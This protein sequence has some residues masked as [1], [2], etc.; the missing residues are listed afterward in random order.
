[1]D[2]PT[3]AIRELRYVLSDVV[4]LVLEHF[5]AIFVNH[6]SIANVSLAVGVIS[7]KWH[8]QIK[9][10]NEISQTLSTVVTH[11]V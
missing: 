1:M 2:F 8:F 5:R 6:H 7:K 3:A 9:F 4:I 11:V 10:Q